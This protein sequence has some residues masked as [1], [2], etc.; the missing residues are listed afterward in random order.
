MVSVAQ[1]KSARLWGEW[2]RVQVLS[3]TPVT[4]MSY[5]KKKQKKN[6]INQLKWGLGWI[7]AVLLKSYR[8]FF[9]KENQMRLPQTRT[10][11]Q[12]LR[13]RAKVIRPNNLKINEW[14]DDY[15]NRCVIEGK[16]VEI[17][18]QY[19]LSKDLET[20]YA[21]Q[22]NQF[23]PLKAER[24]MFTKTI[25]EIVSVFT[26]NGLQVN[27]YVTFNSSFLERGRVT[28]KIL[29][30]YNNMI[31]NLARESN[32]L[33]E[34]LIFF[35]WEKDVLGGRPQPNQ[36]VFVNFTSLVSQEAFELDMQ[37]LLARVKQYKD[38]TKTETEL[39][40]EEKFKI[41]CEV[42]EG[43]FMMSSESPFNQS[44]FILIPL[45][46]PERYVFFETLASGFQKRIV[47]IIKLYPWRMDAND[48][49]YEI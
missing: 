8:R 34:Y 42:E 21:K 40:E 12:W 19:C 32:G 11:M 26:Q 22:G 17:I 38:F 41:A 28:N 39:R 47:S 36:E 14:V 9:P 49:R 13:E 29:D 43:R 37:N 15:V 25:P 33:S 24:D 1:Q 20:R 48:L 5:K 45:E 2:L 35:D 4:N 18:T 7:E 30:A 46:F 27:W 3:E 16:R 44:D 6:I 31:Q 23:F 10:I